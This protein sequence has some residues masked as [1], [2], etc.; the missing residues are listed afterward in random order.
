MNDSI[1]QNHLLKGVVLRSSV[2]TSKNWA[3]HPRLPPQYP[4]DGLE[5]RVGAAAAPV[6]EVVQVK[7]PNH[8]SA[9]P[10]FLDVFRLCWVD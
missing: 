1:V 2:P 3:G 10:Q 6:L 8:A 4:V 5:E 7:G 9:Q